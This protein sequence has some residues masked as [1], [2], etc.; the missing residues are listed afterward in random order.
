MDNYIKLFH[1]NLHVE[2]GGAR[3]TSVTSYLIAESEVVTENHKLRP[4]RID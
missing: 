4:R 3:C 1:C 2:D